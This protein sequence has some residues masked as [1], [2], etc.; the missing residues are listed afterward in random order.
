MND[1]LTM[2]KNIFYYSIIIV[3]LLLIDNTKAQITLNSISP[4]SLVGN[5]YGSV[6]DSSTGNPIAGAQIY[7]FTN[8]LQKGISANSI[9]TN[10]GNYIQPE[11]SSAV[12]YGTSDSKGMFLINSVHT[13][14]PCKPYTII[15]KASGYNLV[16]IDQVPV[17]PGAVMA[18]QV[19]AVLSHS[20]NAK[21]YNGN[22]KNGPFN[23]RDEIIAKEKLQKI[24][25]SSSPNKITDTQYLVYAT[26]EGLVGGTCANGHIIVANDHFV[27][28]PSFLVLNKNDK[29]YDF[30]V[31]VSYGNKSVI[32]PVWDVGPW[33]VKDD[34]WNPDSLRQIYSTLHHGGQIGLG[35]GVPESQAAYYYNYNQDW[36]GDFNGSGSD[37]YKIKLPAGI[38][39]ADGTFWND[40]SLTDNSWVH[41]DYLWRPGV[42]LGDS[43]TAINI[44]PVTSTV[45]GSV[46]GNEQP[47]GKGII[48][49]G[50]KGA[51]YSSTYYI[52][53]KIKWNDNVTGWSFEKNLKRIDTRNVNVTIQTVPAGLGFSMDGTAYTAPYT[54]SFL[55]DSSHTLSTIAQ[56]VG[57]IRYNW[58]SWSDKRQNPHII[59]PYKD[60]T[61]TANFNLQYLL[62][63]NYNPS[64][65]GYTSSAPV[66]WYNPNTKV[67]ITAVSNNG[68]DFSGWSGDTTYSGNPITI[69]VWKP[70][71]ITANFSLSTGIK[72]ELNNVPKNY[73]LSQNY[74]NP[75][76]PSTVI[77]YSLPVDSKVRL[78]IYNLLGQQIS[79][80][81]NES[82]SSGYHS[83]KFN[84]EY[85]S[86]GIYLYKITAVSSD[87]KK[88]FSE[89]KKLIL[90]K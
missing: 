58:I 70:F 62:K 10:E 20:P 19:D 29:T 78:I 40:L 28:L 59:F 72:D 90:M 13:P 4:D 50:P 7:L 14:M 23:Y 35:E 1:G 15:V 49:D 24:S 85:L 83:I 66:N 42:T 89:M 55:P 22:I 17:L 54:F 67:S 39:L 9:Q 65:G 26:R 77:N 32:A 12:K 74:P 81:V 47:N 68:Y 69:T 53:W 6:I 11:Y 64:G 88:E 79:E 44:V 16:I 3:L 80:L 2:I 46:I 57:N 33:N 73:S 61:Y 31:K 21:Y 25:P 41:V 34:Y 8:A 30:Q 36:S 84:G 71:N 87:G 45:G 27:A 82:E 38:D 43:V 48:I 37:Y 52:W 18:L 60:I 76:N 75:F 63:I 86:S 56:S 51:Y 5:V